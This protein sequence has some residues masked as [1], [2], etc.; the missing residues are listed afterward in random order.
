MSW[1]TVRLEAV[2]TKITDGTHKTPKYVEGG[3]CFLS[4][5]NLS[6]G[7]LNFT[8]CKYITAEEHAQLKK[9]CFPEAGDVM[10]SKSGSLGEGVIV[11]NVD[12]EFSIFESLALLK[13]NKSKVVPRFLQQLLSAPQS[14]RYFQSITTGLAVKHLHLVDLRRMRLALPSIAEQTAIADLLSTWDAAIEKTEKLIV[15][16]E[17]RFLWLQND[18]I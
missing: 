16:K 3:V 11:P 8:N 6:Q 9:R 18:L 5:K 13:T 15:A 10:L 12:F 7:H 14:K 17:K 2:C 4:A 1:E